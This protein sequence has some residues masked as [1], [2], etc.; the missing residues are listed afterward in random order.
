QKESY[1]LFIEGALH[2][3]TAANF[4]NKIRSKLYR[5]TPCPVIMVK[6]L[7]KLEK[8]V[9]IFKEEAELKR[10]VVP[11]LKIFKKASIGLDLMYYQFAESEELPQDSNEDADSILHNAR[12]ILMEA[13]W[14]TGENRSFRGLPEKLSEVL[15][16]YGLVI[17]PFR[18]TLS[19]KGLLLEFLSR[20]PS[21]I[22]LCW[23]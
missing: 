2:T 3:F 13:G 17:S 7:V 10:L 12:Q 5:H 15:R 1:D 23:Q 11:F 4:Y 20:I 9:I 21:P 16:D 18:R 8:M 22:L 14:Q 6:N 19:R